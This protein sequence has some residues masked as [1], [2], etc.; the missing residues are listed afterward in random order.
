MYK[1]AV[2]CTALYKTNREKADT[3]FRNHTIRFPDGK[4]SYGAKG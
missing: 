2:P 1:P 4:Q 3:H